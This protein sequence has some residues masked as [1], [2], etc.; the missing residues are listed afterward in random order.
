MLPH[1]PLSSDRLEIQVLLKSVDLGLSD[2]SAQFFCKVIEER[3]TFVFVRAFVVGRPVCEVDG[4][5][6]VLK[7]FGWFTYIRILG[8]SS[9]ALWKIKLDA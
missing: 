6:L 1:K 3:S 4:R 5:D 8:M 7:A 2:E 9:E